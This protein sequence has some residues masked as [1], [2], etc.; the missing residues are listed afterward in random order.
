MSK[1][2]KDKKPVGHPILFTDEY[3]VKVREMRRQERLEKKLK[4][5]KEQ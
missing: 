5:K 2:K 4:E 3:H 1:Q